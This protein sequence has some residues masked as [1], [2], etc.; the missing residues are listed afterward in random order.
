M[1]KNE[2]FIMCDCKTVFVGLL[3]SLT[4]ELLQIFT[5]RATDVNDLMT[6]TLGAFIGYFFGLMIR[7]FLHPI[8][9]ETKRVHIPMVFGIAFFTMFFLHPFFS[10]VIYRIFS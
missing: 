9:P 8:E 4:I 3:T 7:K 1:K 2:I 10:S 6:N 5:F